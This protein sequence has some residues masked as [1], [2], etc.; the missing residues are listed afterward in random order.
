MITENPELDA[1][2]HLLEIEKNASILVNEAHVE[3]DKR[4]SLARAQFS[5]KSKDNLEKISEEL[6]IE[7]QNKIDSISKKYAD[8]FNEY[9]LS[10]EK[11]VLNKKDFSELLEKLL[12]N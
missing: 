5:A 4:I 8:E 7:Y 6:E 11:K 2:N 3:A 12:L 10:L 9:K 1:I